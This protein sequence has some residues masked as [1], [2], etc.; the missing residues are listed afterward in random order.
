VKA[1]FI[2]YPEI[3][4]LKQKHNSGWHTF[5]PF[6]FYNKEEQNAKLYD[7]TLAV[8][9]NLV[10]GLNTLRPRVLILGG[11]GEGAQLAARLSERVDLTVISSLAG[12]VSEPKLPKGQVRV[13]G[14]GGLDGLASYLV[15]EEIKVVV[16]ATHPFAAKISQNA[17]LACSRTVL[18]FIAL[19]RPAWRK[20]AGDRWYEVPDFE[21]AAEFV[22]KKMG[23]VFLSIGRQE[24]GSFSECSNAWFLIRAI[25]EPTE[26]L[27]PHRRVLLRRGPFEFNEELQ[28]LRDHSINCLVSKNSGGLATYTKIE[29]AR[30]L[31]IPVVMIDRPIKHTVQ[32]VE[33]IEEAIA[34]LDYLIRSASGMP[35]SLVGI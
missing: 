5:R 6:S 30:S 23:R 19:L 20:L 11:T 2:R 7:I 34:K 29:A 17:E 22:D 10:M 9:R 25:E 32:A 21:S 24:L 28:L 26:S 4:R 3:G 1:I 8:E 33:T 15:N 35:G 16:D 13:G 12:R 14:F 27:P 31:D 18:P